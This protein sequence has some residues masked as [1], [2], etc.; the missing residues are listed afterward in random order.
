MSSASV[1]P[2]QNTCGQAG[3][4]ATWWLSARLIM[5]RVRRDYKKRKKN[6]QRTRRETSAQDGLCGL[7]RTLPGLA[8]SPAGA[9][10]STK[11]TSHTT[12]DCRCAL[13]CSLQSRDHQSRSRQ[14]DS[15]SHPLAG[16]ALFSDRSGGMPPG[17][18]GFGHQTASRWASVGAW[19][20]PDICTSNR[21]PRTWR[22]RCKAAPLGCGLLRERL[23]GARP[24][25]R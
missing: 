21:R 8:S 12:N 16:E 23:G 25:G 1:G 11:T 15:G 19:Q 13:L 9:P 24:S 14:A 5:R 4:R 17:T 2:R 20:L 7:P 3:G 6:L 18:G 22:E 10:L